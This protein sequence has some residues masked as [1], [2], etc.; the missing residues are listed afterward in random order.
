M[1]NH[2]AERLVGQQS[3]FTARFIDEQT[4]E[5]ADPATIVFK[6]RPAQNAP[7]QTFTYGAES[8]VT[9]VSEGVYE[10]R[11]P[12]YTVGAVASVRVVSTGLAA[13]DDATVLVSRT[14]LD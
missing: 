7:I 1:S 14:D 10:F 5:P 3:V 11:A 8:E 9:R 6:F 13:A 2:L 4:G 12:V